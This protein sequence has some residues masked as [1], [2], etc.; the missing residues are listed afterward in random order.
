MV[1]EGDSVSE[2]QPLARFDGERARLIMLRA[3]ADYEKTAREHRRLANLHERG[4]VSKASFE[5]LEYDVE[6]AKAAFELARLDYEH[7]VV[8]ATI[9]GVVS[10]RLIKPGSYVAEGD[11][12]FVVTG[13]QT[14]HAYLDIPQTELA[15]F[16][17]G[18]PAS[19]AVAHAPGESFDAVVERISPTIDIDSGTFR[20]TLAIDN[21]AGLLAPGMFAR[22]AV[23]WQKR[24]DAIVIPAGAAV[25]EDDES[26]VYVIENG[27]VRRRPVVLG[28]RSRG[29]VEVVEGLAAEERIV[30]SGQSRLRDGSRVVAQSTSDADSVIG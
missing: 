14:L 18:H 15:K 6:A 20:A 16:A 4:L 17:P 26:V 29:Q 24:E 9:D 23:A 19:L 8:R 22:F 12:A 3:K 5:S 13:T 30:L 11:I 27:A 21:G 25:I 7:S 2:G 1:E 28:L 10:R